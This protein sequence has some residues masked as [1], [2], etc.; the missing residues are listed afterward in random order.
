MFDGEDLEYQLYEALREGEELYSLNM[1]QKE[2]TDALQMEMK[3]L[4]EKIS[5]KEIS[6]NED[7]QRGALAHEKTME[8]LYYETEQVET[9]RNVLKSLH[10]K[11]RTEVSRFE[12]S[13]YSSWAREG[14][15]R[16]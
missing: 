14:G 3:Q 5:R 2:E 10:E 1:E 8:E 4:Q 9:L 13:N 15:S 11:Y 16:S 6:F 7:I 12:E